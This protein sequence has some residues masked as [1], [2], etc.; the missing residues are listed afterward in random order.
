MTLID[1]S[2]DP[3]TAALLQALDAAPDDRQLLLVIAD[4]W[5]ELEFGSGDGWRALAAT[6]RKVKYFNNWVWAWIK[7]EEVVGRYHWYVPETCLPTDWFEAI[8]STDFP[9][10]TW[11][12]QSWEGSEEKGAAKAYTEA[13]LAVLLLPEHRRSALLRGEL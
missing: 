3:T 9:H 12:E 6:G 10:A 4:R 13:A 2:A 8:T 11:I 5:D 7:A 1:Y